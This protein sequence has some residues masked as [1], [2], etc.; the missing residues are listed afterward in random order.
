MILSSIIVGSE[1]A[2]YPEGM[3]LKGVEMLTTFIVITFLI[4]VFYT[5]W[6]LIGLAKIIY[7]KPV[8]YIFNE[9]DTPPLVSILKPLSGIDDNLKENLRSFF[10]QD[11]ANFELLFGVQDIDDPS[12]EIVNSLINIYPEVT[13]RLI[14][15]PRGNV[16]NP[17]VANLIGITTKARGDILI[18][19]DSNIRAPKKYVSLSVESLKNKD[20]GLVTHLIRGKGEKSLGSLL[21]NLQMNAYL[22]PS[23]GLSNMN[24]RPFVIGKS[25]VVRQSEF[26]ALGGF[27]GL[28]NVLAEDYILGR[29]YLAAGFK[30]AVGKTIIDDIS[31]TMTIQAFWN[32][33]ARWSLIRSKLKPLVYPLEPLTYPLITGAILSLISLTIWPL[34]L[35]LTL[36]ITRDMIA[37]KLL[38]GWEGI[39]KA[40]IISPIKEI[41]LFAIWA[42]SPFQRTIAWRKTK[43]YLSAGTRIYARNI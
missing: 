38:R 37:W 18:V 1:I 31:S 19:S 13:A 34:L 25:M 30:I 24:K 36:T 40:L 35:G 2:I 26:E 15:H 21:N 22:A 5:L 11:Y 29:M 9:T 6:S 4:S 33:N 8:S 41:L 14:I 20:V 7:E 39:V 42:T 28:R 16:L 32:R 27:E 43:V 17:K 12:I 10:E 3:F 23:I